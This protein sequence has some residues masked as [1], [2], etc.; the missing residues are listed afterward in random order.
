MTT[1]CFSLNFAR[2]FTIVKSFQ[3]CAFFVSLRRYVSIGENKPETKSELNNFHTQMWHKYVKLSVR[4]EKTKTK[5]TAKTKRK[6]VGFECCSRIRCR[7]LF[8]VCL[9]QFMLLFGFVSLFFSLILLL[10][11]IVFFCSSIQCM[12]VNE[13]PYVSVCMCADDAMIFQCCC[14][15]NLFG[16]AYI[17]LCAKHKTM[18]IFFSSSALFFLLGVLR[19]Y[20]SYI[21]QKTKNFEWK[22]ASDNSNNSKQLERVQNWQ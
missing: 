22:S 19:F 12:C 20:L 1:K 15:L 5:P 4:E 8:C 18:R 9:W 3:S 6:I 13:C 2:R 21:I 7:S 16:Y 17:K 11:L 10:R 14:F